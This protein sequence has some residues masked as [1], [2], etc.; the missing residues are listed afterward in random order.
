MTLI[1]VYA[2]DKG[3]DIQFTLQDANGDPIDLE[4][5]TSLSL[6]AQK[7]GASVVALTGAM[8]VISAALGTCKYVVQEN[9]LAT[10]G[11][12][13]AEIQASFTGGKIVTFGDFVIR[14][15]SDLPR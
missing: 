13:Y 11:D 8:T 10:P 4:N 7:Q 14:V 2:N 15:L 1:K 3:Y 6:K 9:E 5:I 12:Y